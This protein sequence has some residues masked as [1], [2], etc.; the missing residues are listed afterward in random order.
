MR[1]FVIAE[2]LER[3]GALVNF[4]PGEAARLLDKLASQFP[5]H[6]E[7]AGWKVRAEG[8]RNMNS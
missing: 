8:Y 7:S 2:Q 6:P 1:D 3:A 5:E 4:K